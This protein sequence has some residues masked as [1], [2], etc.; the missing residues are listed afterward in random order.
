MFLGAGTYDI[1]AAGTAPKSFEYLD[2]DDLVTQTMAAFVSTTANC[3]RCHAH[4]FDPISQEDY[5]AVQA[6]FSGIGKGDIAYDE[7]SAVSQKRRH[8]TTLL[9][10][11]NKRD[12]AVLLTS[13]NQ[14]VVDS[15]EKERGAGPR[16]NPLAAETFTSTEGTTL[17]RLADGS[18][19]SSGTRPDTDTYTITTAPP[20]GVVSAM[21]VDLLPH[22]SL[23]L[24]GPG[25]TDNGNVHIT[26]FELRLFRPGSAKPE[27]LAIRRATSDF[28]QVGYDVAKSIDG[29]L[30]TSWAIHPNVGV[31][32]HAVLELAAPPT[33]EAGAKIVVAMRQLQPGH[34]IGRFLISATSAASAAAL[35]AVAETALA[36]TERT[37]DE[38]VA[39]AAAVFRTLAADELAALPAQAKVWAAGKTAVN[40]RGNITIPEPR[41]IHVLRRGDLDKPGAEASPG[42]LSAI[43]ALSARFADTAAEAPRRAALADWIAD[44]RNPLTWRSIVNRVWHYHFGRGLC[45][46]PSDFGRMGGVPS[47]PEL[48]DWLAV[49]FRDDAKGS[50][51]ALHRLIVT[52]ETYRQSSAHNAAGAALDSDNRALWRMS[53]TR[54]D[55]DEIRDSVFAASG[56]L[57]LAMGGPGIQ[58]FKTSPGPQSTP[59][60]DY[61]A[62]DWAAPGAA[63]RSIYRVVW[64][65]IADPL[66]ESLDFPDM[67]LLSPVRGFSASPLQSLSLFNND[68]L[69]H[70]SA[71]FAARIEKSDTAM[72]EKIRAAFRIALQR[73]PSPEESTDF[74][75][76]A[77]KRGL[78]TACRVLFNTNEFLF[79]D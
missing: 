18:I 45:D 43:T 62:F 32:H 73:E 77:D 10:A 19:L 34:I 2:R 70:H 17:E 47:H 48:L 9:D 15:W 76:I 75:A 11:A 69:L 56:A 22:D 41:K 5:F 59:V 40:E 26:E 53:R 57:D 49:W 72:A 12:A 30:K 25:R 6:V 13:Q 21:R 14:A 50:L 8:W 52:S 42:A 61:N 60:L 79:I 54:L 71:Q 63:R 16:W 24:K 51:K 44:S 67:G 58:H 65:G 46:T 33:L 37:A 78:A 38:K 64:R 3:A 55:A 28:D 35:P 4:K 29:D 23:P 74:T 68:F 7:E 36:K 1:S 31:A 20:P 66:M 39:I 27:K